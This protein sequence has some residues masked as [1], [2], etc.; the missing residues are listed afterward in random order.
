MPELFSKRNLICT[1]V[2]LR[3]A[4]EKEP[5]FTTANALALVGEDLRKLHGIDL[6]PYYE[7]AELPYEVVPA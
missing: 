3:R 7:E 6:R 2:D 5:S 1:W 4:L